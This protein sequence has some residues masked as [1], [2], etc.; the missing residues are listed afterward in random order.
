MTTTVSDGLSNWAN[1]L[2]FTAVDTPQT[3][4]IM[5]LNVTFASAPQMAVQAYKL[6]FSFPAWFGIGPQ[7]YRA[8]FGTVTCK[9]A[10]ITPGNNNNNNKTQTLDCQSKSADEF[11][12]VFILNTNGSL[13]SNH[14]QMAVI[15]SDSS[16]SQC[17][18]KSWCSPVTLPSQPEIA[19]NKIPDGYLEMPL[20]GPQPPWVV[21]LVFGA[22]GLGLGIIL[23][24]YA[25]HRTRSRRSS[26]LEGNNNTDPFG[27]Q[28]N[29]NN[30][31]PKASNGNLTLIQQVALNQQRNN[32]AI[33]N[34]R[35]GTPKY[36]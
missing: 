7:P 14:V 11:F 26:L 36:C 5:L 35:P 15:N 25:R 21:T 1:S 23:Y 16:L 10:T 18:L 8:P 6:R 9:S 3:G 19:R 2:C 34:S 20:M 28:T 31:S 17:S 22:I 24:C 33:S 13:P 27:T 30:P 4:P 29:S 12:A 32:A